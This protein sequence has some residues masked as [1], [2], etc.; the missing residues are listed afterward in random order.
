MGE[1][2]YYTQRPI[3]DVNQEISNALGASIMDALI[4]EFLR[5]FP[6]TVARYLDL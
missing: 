1:V 5:T 4:A 2:K 6:K 3:E